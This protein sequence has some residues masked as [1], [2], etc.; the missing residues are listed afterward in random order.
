MAASGH[1]GTGATVEAGIEAL[2][3][4]GVRLLAGM[5]AL[6]PFFDTSH[7]DY[8]SSGNPINVGSRAIYPA[9]FLRIAF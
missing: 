3:L 8:D 9:A 4:H 2:R 7:T 6:I 5:Q 1:G